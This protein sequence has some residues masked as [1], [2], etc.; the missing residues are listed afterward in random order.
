MA[1][2]FKAGSRERHVT[3]TFQHFAHLTISQ[4]ILVPPLEDDDNIKLDNVNWI[5]VVEKEV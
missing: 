5:L 3:A 1:Q 2:R 4:G